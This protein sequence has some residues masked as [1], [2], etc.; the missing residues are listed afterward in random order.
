[1]AGRLA[2]SLLNQWQQQMRE[3]PQFFQVAAY[4]HNHN[5]EVYFQGA[6]SLVEIKQLQEDHYSAIQ[7]LY[8]QDRIHSLQTNLKM[9]KAGKMKTK[10]MMMELLQ[11]NQTVP[12]LSKQMQNL[13]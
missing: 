7:P 1:L 10:M 13:P 4:L 2:I 8:F 3:H 5:Q 11:L 6:V 12:L 9:R